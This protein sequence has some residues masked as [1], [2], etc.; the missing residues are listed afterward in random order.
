MAYQFHSWALPSGPFANAAYANGSPT[1]APHL[2]AGAQAIHGSGTASTGAAT[3]NA[4]EWA[5]VP[6][7]QRP[8][9]PPLAADDAPTPEDF[10]QAMAEV[11]AALDRGLPL[12]SRDS[13]QTWLGQEMET[14]RGGR[15][16]DRTCVLGCHLAR[17]GGASRAHNP[18]TGLPWTPTTYA[19]RH[20]IAPLA[21]R[22]RPCLEERA[23][24]IWRG[25]EAAAAAEEEEERR[26]RAGSGDSGVLLPWAGVGL[27]ETLARPIW[28]GGTEMGM[29]GAGVQ[30]YEGM[31]APPLPFDWEEAALDPGWVGPVEGVLERLFPELFGAPAS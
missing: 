28:D 11:L 7:Q 4:A 1:A 10:N 21:Q 30:G 15:C 24:A 5:A 14:S 26:R 9:P 25:R 27:E 12:P 13:W 6:E 23:R 31:A 18:A 22:Y 17:R 20:G 2:A 8:C 19:V 3:T 29:L 16:R